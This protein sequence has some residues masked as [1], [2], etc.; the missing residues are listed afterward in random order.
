MNSRE[1]VNL[2]LNHQKPDRV[3]LDLGGSPVTGMHVSSVYK[4]RQALGLDPPGTPVKVIEPYQML[5]EIQPDLLDALGVNVVPL[6][7]PDSMFGYALKDWKPWTFFDGTPVLVPGGFNT[8]PE[9]NGD[10]LMYPQGNSSFAPSGRMPAGG[11]YFDAIV[12]QPPIDDARLDPAENL[13]EFQ[14]VSESDLAHYEQEA[15]R[16]F[17]DTDKAIFANFG[18]TGFGD[19]ALVPGVQLPNPAGIRDMTEWYMSTI[20]RRDYIWRVF[21][22][23][24]EIGLENLKHI[25]ARVGEKVSIL[26]VSG[27]DFGAQNGPLISPKAYRDLFQ[28]FHKI[29][30]TWVHENTTWKTFIHSCGSVIKLYPDFIEAGFDI[31]NPVQTSAAAMDPTTLVKQFGERV[32][33]WGGGVDT[34]STL[35]FGSPQAVRAQVRERMQIFGSRC[36]FVFNPI[37]NV[38][39]NIPVENLL[40][41]YQAVEDFR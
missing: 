21:E 27:A 17:T 6:W 32:T 28:P 3:P 23:Q 7:G 13:E 1:R 26:F 37:H 19:I 16:L 2:A 25:H 31:L 41:L 9:P 5:G 40:A 33:F 35:P 4:L 30:N 11:F 20:T 34:Q 22:G 24:C 29:I 39:A 10:I 38:Q 18:G 15:R 12:R 14:L 8:Q 36:G